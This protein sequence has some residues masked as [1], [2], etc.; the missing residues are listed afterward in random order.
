MNRISQGMRQLGVIVFFSGIAAAC[1]GNEMVP[2]RSPTETTSAPVAE[3]VAK[4]DFERA[5]RERD[6]ARE[7]LRQ[8]KAKHEEERSKLQADIQ[9]RKEHE[10]L[11]ARAWASVVSAE[12]ELKTLKDKAARGPARDRQKLEKA[13]TDAKAKLTTVEGHLRKI[14]S[15]V[16]ATWP[17]LKRSV[18]MAI[19]DLDRAIREAG[20]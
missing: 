16:S 5:V 14:P 17:D 12:S 9:A 6:E 7:T 2:A 11:T 4:G 18:E 15:A 13:I 10:E 19:D 3:T 1:G 20:Q 8:E